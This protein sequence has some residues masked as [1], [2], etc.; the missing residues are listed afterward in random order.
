[1]IAGMEPLPHLYRAAASASADGDVLLDTL[2][3]TALQT[4]SPKEFG[5]SGEHWSPEA[6]LV[7]AVA[8]CFVL[9]FY[10]LA[11]AHRLHWLRIACTATGTLDRVQGG[12]EFVWFQLGVEL[13][14]ADVADE[15]QARRVLEK[16]DKGCLV[17]R[18]LKAPVEVDVHIDAA[19]PVPPREISKEAI[20]S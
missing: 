1:V 14:I 3:A 12:L 19:P 4:E 17:A 2:G 18:S 11:K 15:A 7:G 6:L 20:L 13:T 10:A 16:A 8:D 5:G 9:T